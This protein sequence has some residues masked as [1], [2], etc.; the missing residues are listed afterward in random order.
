MS[1]LDA[2]VFP[3]GTKPYLEC[4][5]LYN[6]LAHHLLTQPLIKEFTITFKNQ[7]VGHPADEQTAVDI[8]L[9]RG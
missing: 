9:A 6:C 2:C 1:L 7:L 3:V 4:E 5:V 8:E